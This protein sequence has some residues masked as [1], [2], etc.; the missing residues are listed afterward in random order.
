M[1]GGLAARVLLLTACCNA[2]LG[3]YRADS[4]E[5]RADAQ[6]QEHALTKT[7][8]TLLERYINLPFKP[9]QVKW[10]T[11]KQQ[12]GGDWGITAL[13]FLRDED[14]RKLLAS[15]ETKR[16][17]SMTVA[18]EDMTNWFPAE[19]QSDYASE[20]ASKAAHIEVDAIQIPGSVFAAPSKSPAIHGRA[21]VFEK[22]NL[23]YLNLFTM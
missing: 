22:H 23:V 17:G 20:L 8:I 13:L 16:G 21:L 6:Q 15:T 5:S 11:S 9:T 12:G 4:A 1:R 10:S 18:R 19:V 3:C 7:D 14:T 2:Q